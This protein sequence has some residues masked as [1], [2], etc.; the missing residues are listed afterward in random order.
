MNQEEFDQAMDALF[1]LIPP[2]DIETWVNDEKLIEPRTPVA[3]FETILPT[4]KSDDEGQLRRTKRKTKVSVYEPK[5]G[6]K[7]MLYELGIPVVEAD[8]FHIDV[9]QKVPLNMSRDNV[10]PAYKRELRALV[11]ANAHSHLSE[12]DS[13]EAWVSDAMEHE[14]MKEHPDAVET[15]VTHRYGEK[16]AIQDPHDPEANFDRVSEGYTI[17][18]GRSF[19][20]GAWTNI[21]STGA[22]LPSGKIKPSRKMVFSA[23]PDAPMIE[24]LDR[25]KWSDGMKIIERIAKDLAMELMDVKL[26]VEI[27]NL[28]LNHH[29]A[30]IGA[31]YGSH[32]GS[33]DTDRLSFNLRRLGYKWFEENRNPEAVLD[34]LLHE[35]AH[36]YEGNHLDS[37]Y[38]RAISKLGARLTL[39]VRKQPSII[40]G[41]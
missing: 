2:P 15:V 37:K 8:R 14:M 33:K 32:C 29:Y 27:V 26:V 9:H 7:P 35:F 24:S 38:H 21:R 10:T 1:T 23:D 11:L 25:E 30:G 4:M 20:K 18:P 34:I 22:A 36:H 16:R 31:Y 39:L 41:L 12:T 40:E 3:T 19:G 28:P 17:I 5:N 13:T 6:E